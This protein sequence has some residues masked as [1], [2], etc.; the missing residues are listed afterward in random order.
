MSAG[1]PVVVVVAAELA[2]MHGTVATIGSVRR[3]TTRPLVFEILT[4]GLA[5]R[6]RRRL[7]RAAGPHPV[8][9]H[10]TTRSQVLVGLGGRDW[11]WRRIVLPSVVEQPRCLFLDSDLLI[12]GDVGELWDMPMT[13]VLAAGPDD[14]MPTAALRG[15]AMSN[16]GGDAMYGN[17][18][19]LLM[20]LDRIRILAVPERTPDAVV[21]WGADLQARDQDVLNLL[22]QG[23][24]GRLPAEWNQLYP[25]V[26][27]C[28][29]PKVVHFI[30]DVW[31]LRARHF[32]TDIAFRSELL[33]TASA[34]SG[35]VRL[36]ALAHLESALSPIRRL[37]RAR[38]RRRSG[39]G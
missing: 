39:S 28:R 32:L 29:D 23:N 15:A 3:N 12:R 11:E 34:G 5:D 9:L 24:V 35:D 4:Y 10:T 36:R 13:D 33:T 25:F 19:V 2:E 18:G 17:F 6:H 30:G 1:D 14:Y 22:F 7:R 16:R 20:D 31:P 37:R 8:H 38:Q 26:G 21:T 27:R